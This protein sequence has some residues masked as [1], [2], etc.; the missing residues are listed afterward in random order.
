MSLEANQ[1]LVVITG[2]V[3][4]KNAQAADERQA[5]ETS[6]SLKTSRAVRQ[7]SGLSLEGGSGPDTASISRSGIVAL[8]SAQNV[9]D[10]SVIR[11]KDTAGQ[12]LTYSTS[13]MAEYPENA[14]EVQANQTP[15]QLLAL[16]TDQ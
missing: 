3:Q 13:Q 5:T 12:A 4:Q 2:G 14:V 7:S 16:V 11:D 6:S 15:Q 10:E 8:E 1:G 9:N